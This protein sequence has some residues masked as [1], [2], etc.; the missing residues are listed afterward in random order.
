MNNQDWE[1]Y[2]NSAE[3][4]KKTLN[5]EDRTGI[6]YEEDLEFIES[7][8]KA[9]QHHENKKEK[10]SI[11][12]F[13]DVFCMGAV[14]GNAEYLKAYKK[15]KNKSMKELIEEVKDS[16]Q[17]PLLFIETML[18]QGAQNNQTF[19]HQGISLSYSDLYD[20]YSQMRSNFSNYK[21][22]EDIEDLL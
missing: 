3:E 4:L 13:A 2:I 22:G 6:E 7:I 11:K 17:N 19:D 9:I 8:D 18:K 1:K 10:E 15:A 20:I 12:G 16:N 21:K 14:S 5:I